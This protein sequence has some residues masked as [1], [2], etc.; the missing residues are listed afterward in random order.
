[1]FSF[2]HKFWQKIS[3]IASA[4]ELFCRCY[5]SSLVFS[6]KIAFPWFISKSSIFE[7]RISCNNSLIFYFSYFTRILVWNILHDMNSVQ[8]FIRMSGS[9]RRAYEWRILISK[10]VLEYYLGWSCRLFIC[11]S[12]WSEGAY[13]AVSVLSDFP[14]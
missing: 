2:S 5:Y 6:Y 13:V 7:H 10:R 8:R 4:V 14:P 12:W 9:K 1:M 3:I 11:L